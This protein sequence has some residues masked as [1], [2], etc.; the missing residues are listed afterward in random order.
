MHVRIILILIQLAIQGYSFG[1]LYEEKDF[2][3]FTNTD[4]LSGQHITGLTQD[5]YGNIWIST[6]RGLNRFDGSTFKQFLHTSGKNSIPDNAVFSMKLLPKN[7]LAIA[8]DDGAQIINTLTLKTKDLDIP[9][10]DALRYWSNACKYVSVD[11]GG[12]Y[13]VST[14]TGFYIFSSSGSLKKRYDRY[15]EKDIGISWMMFGSTIFQLPDGNLMQK[16]SEGLLVHDRV[17]NII[18]D[19][20][21][22][23][24]AIK[25][26]TPQLNSQQLFLFVSA[27]DILLFNMEKNSFDMIDIRNGNIRSFPACFTLQ[28]EIGWQSNP[29][30]LGKNTWAVNCRNKG[31]FLLHIDTLTKTISCSPEKYFSDRACNILFSDN[32]N[33]LW[34][35]T[36]SGLYMQNR[37]S[38]IIQTS[39][40]ETSDKDLFSISS[41]YVLKNKIFAGTDKHGVFIIDK[42]TDK[43]IKNIRFFSGTNL[44]GVVSLLLVHP[45]TLWVAAYPGLCWINTKNFTSGIVMAYNL[46]EKPFKPAVL[47]RDKKKNIWIA[48]NQLNKIIFYNEVRKQ[49]EILNSTNNNLLKVNSINSFAEDNRGRIWVGGDAIARFDPELQKFDTLIEH[50]STQKSRKKGYTVM[51]DSHGDIWTTVNEDGMAR[52][53]G[54]ITHIRSD[55]FLFDQSLAVSPTLLQ[56]KIFIGTFNGISCLNIT[57]FKTVLFTKDDGLPDRKLT[58]TH[59]VYDSSENSIWFACE[60]KIAKI[61]LSSTPYSKPPVLRFSELQIINDTIIH[62]PSTSVSLKYDQNNINIAF[63]AVNF[64]DAENMRFAYRF[65]NRKD[66]TWIETGTQ[67]NILLTN[68]A[69]GNYILEA[70][71]YSF[72]NKWNPQT[73]EL[74]IIVSPPFWRT[75]WFYTVIAILLVTFIYILHRY[76]IN[77]IRQ[78]N[79]LDRALAQTEMKALHSQMNPHFIFNCLNSIREM[80]LNNDNRQASHY[81]SKFAQLIRTTLENSTRHFINLKNTIDYLKRYLEMEQIRKDNFTYS[82]EVSEELEPDEIFLPP[83]LI[84]PFIENAI[85]HGV[86]AQKQMQIT[87]SFFKKNDELI[88]IVEDDGIGIET[89]VKKKENDI[90]RSSLGI[91]NIRQRIQL[92]NEKYNF[93]SKVTIED[94]STLYSQ[95]DTGTRVTIY[96]PVKNTYI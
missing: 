61:N 25:K 50:L 35:G 27:Y 4:G 87:I 19:V 22:Y 21:N 53:T 26:I 23:Y 80:I 85:W 93:N 37:P 90:N 32:Q 46:L 33:R 96:L 9:S 45:D 63:N 38:Q 13:G 20:A 41:L 52:L 74:E 54:K 60:N 10:P 56:D 2:K 51:N 39:S 64:N 70:K 79:D 31:F 29:V 47:F 12:N 28:N 48:G 7:E 73:K 83:M 55:F 72:D 67:Q 1:Q 89:S 14:K 65:K 84:Q 11:R 92:L 40:I 30:L 3:H 76:R 57:D 86:A 58:T 68:I 43:I 24:P 36:N 94:K 42:K 34:V 71:V 6:L 5:A 15:T 75:T 17:K 62:Y 66:S 82:I 77:Q 95:K 16:T 8:T 78:K 49:F 69:P 59:F 18:A 88:C 44:T 91:Q 81:L